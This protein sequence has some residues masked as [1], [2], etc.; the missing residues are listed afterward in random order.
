MQEG[1]ALVKTSVWWMIVGQLASFQHLYF[2]PRGAEEGEVV[3]RFL[4]S[5][6]AFRCPAC[7]TLVL[8]GKEPR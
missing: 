2:F 3:L 7:Q 4:D 8:S 5:R 6:T 1:T